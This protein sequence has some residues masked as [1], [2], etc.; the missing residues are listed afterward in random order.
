MSNGKKL[1]YRNGKAEY[2]SEAEWMQCIRATQAKWAAI[3]AA[4]KALKKA[5]KKEAAKQPKKVAKKRSGWL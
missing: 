1:V 5:V 2:V 3:N 4:E